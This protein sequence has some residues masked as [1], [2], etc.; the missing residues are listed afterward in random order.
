MYRNLSKTIYANRICKFPECVR[1]IVLPN[2]ITVLNC[3]CN[4]K[5]DKFRYRLCDYKIKE[6]KSYQTKP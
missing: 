4:P 1:P 3:V 6:L 5:T 2:N